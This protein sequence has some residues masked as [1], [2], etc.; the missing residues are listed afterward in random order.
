MSRRQTRT[1]AT[2]R[3]VAAHAGVSPTAVSRYLNE[4]IKLPL[5]TEQRIDAAIEALKYRPNPHARSLSRGRSDTIGLVVPDIG[6]TFFAHLAASVEEAAEAR[7]FGLMLC[8]TANRI[9]REL[10]YLERLSRNYVD[11]LLFV[12]N[13]ADDGRLAV[14]IGWSKAVVLLDEDVAGAKAGKIFADNE[15]GGALAAQHLLE[16]GHRRLAYIGGPRDLMSAQERAKG[17][18]SPIAQSGRNVQSNE[19]FGDYTI[20][21]GRRATAAL[22]D[23][24]HTPTAIFSGSDAITLGALAEIRT[25]GLV[26]GADVSLITFDD[27]SPLEFFE[28]PLT[29]V[30][31]SVAEMGRRGVEML[32]KEGGHQAM[33]VERLP[34]ELVRRASV[35]PPRR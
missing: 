22:F 32:A 16:A 8:V 18:R 34:V 30:R 13:H 28:P 11:A 19:L 6:N 27:V 12:T 3:D 26:V 21:H 10:H 17:F 4:A 31:Q 15:G 23:S 2:L 20:E 14:A 7:G 25:R 33:I 9:E 35:A 5:E 24:D 1:H 29:A